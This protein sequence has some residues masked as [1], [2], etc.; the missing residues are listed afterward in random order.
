[1]LLAWLIDTNRR[2]SRKKK[3]AIRENLKSK[4]IKHR[5][6][7]R[8]HLIH[9]RKVLETYQKF[10]PENLLPILDKESILAVNFGDSIV[11]KMTVMFIHF[12][13]SYENN[14]TDAHSHQFTIYNETVR[15]IEKIINQYHG[16]IDK[17]MRDGVLSLFNYPNVM[18]VKAALEISSFF[19]REALKKYIRRYC[20]AWWRCDV[21]H[22]RRS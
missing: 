6:M 18:A 17:F 10:V 16:A 8:Q 11:K 20:L 22:G 19:N 4:L 12:K 2:S 1:M 5:E 13:I 14:N 15:S 9:R 21:R 7:Q 3:A